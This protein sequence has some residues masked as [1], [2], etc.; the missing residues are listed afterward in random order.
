MLSSATDV[1]PTYLV[2]G[3]RKSATVVFGLSVASGGISSA[4]ATAST[5]I[6][7][8]PLAP[9]ADAGKNQLVGPLATV[10]L[11]GSKSTDPYGFPLTYAWT[12][13]SGPTVI[14]ITGSDNPI[15][16][17]T[18]GADSSAPIFQLVV[19]NGETASPPATVVVNVVKSGCGC[20]SGGGGFSLPL[21]PVAFLLAGLRRRRRTR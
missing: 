3:L 7:H 17:F 16:Q 1:K 9:V 12:Q 5:A 15:A 2:K 13:L 11:D 4:P 8:V 20:S 19:S 10:T 14:L 6:T 18:A 21:L